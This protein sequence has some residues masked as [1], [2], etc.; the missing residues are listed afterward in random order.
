MT[1]VMSS[2]ARHPFVSQVHGINQPVDGKFGPDGA[3]YLVDYGAVRDFGQSSRE[4]KFCPP[5][6]PAGIPN[7]FFLS[8]TCLGDGPLVEIPGTGA[9]W[10]IS[11][12]P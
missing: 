1:L 9:I 5:N 12:T 7:P 10:K 11:R 8:G 4:S 3:L 2:T 6:T